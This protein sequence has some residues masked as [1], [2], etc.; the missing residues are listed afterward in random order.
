LLQEASV[1]SDIL[2]ETQ[3]LSTILSASPKLHYPISKK[4]VSSFRSLLLDDAISSSD[5]NNGNDITTGVRIVNMLWNN[6]HN[7]DPL[8]SNF[9]NA[10]KSL[11]MLCNGYSDVAHEVVLGINPITNLNE[12]EAVATSPP[13]SQ[14]KIDFINNHPLSST[15]DI[16]HSLIHRYC[17]GHTIGEGGYTGYQNAKYWIAG[18]PKKLYNANDDD[19]GRDEKEKQH[20]IY[21]KLAQFAIKYCPLCVSTGLVH[22]QNNDNN[23]HNYHKATTHTII[24]G[25]GKHRTVVVDGVVFSATTDAIVYTTTT[26]TNYI[27]DPFRF[28][29]LFEAMTLSTKSPMKDTYV[30]SIVSE[31]S[32]VDDTNIQTVDTENRNDGKPFSLIESLDKEKLQKELILLQ[33]IEICLLL[34][35]ELGQLQ[36]LQ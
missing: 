5:N 15:D 21:T 13:G 36:R 10:A 34:Y 9:S 11:I 20:P 8:V 26:A 31:T 16:V 29:D 24:A 27:W 22:I 4:G 14:I 25:G 19:N 6:K 2:Q 3:L 32:A 18:G 23:N 17:E 7:K 28:I 33:Q 1:L 30:D 12:A 35:H